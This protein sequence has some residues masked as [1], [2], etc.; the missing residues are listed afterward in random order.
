MRQA[1]VRRD[2]LWESAIDWMAGAGV[3]EA[4]GVEMAELLEALAGP[5][6]IAVRG[7]T[8]VGA[9]AVAVALAGHAGCARWRVI[10]DEGPAPR[11]DADAVVRVARGTGD[12]VKHGEVSAHPRIAGARDSRDDADGPAHGPALDRI[13]AEIGE[14]VD[15]EALARTRARRLRRGVAAIAAAHPLVRDELEDL[16]WP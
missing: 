15:D 13:A 11:V 12:V 4:A 7:A 3:G 2:P 8:G 16:L 10:A 9:G 5:P 1:T 6:T 14:L